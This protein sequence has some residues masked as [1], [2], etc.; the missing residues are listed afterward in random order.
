MTLDSYYQDH[1]IEVEPDRLEAYEQMFQWRDGLEPLIAPAKIVEGLSVVDYGCGPGHLAMEIAR[2]VGK[3]GQV[4]GLDINEEFISRTRARALDQG[5]EARVNTEL[6]EGEELPL[7]DASVD[8]V[9][10]K[11]VLEYVPDPDAT[12]REFRRV[13]HPGGLAHVTDSDWGSLIVEPLE[14]G[15]VSAL[16]AAAAVAFRTPLIGR[17]L[18]GI[19]R[20]AGFE[21]VRVRVMANADTQGSLRPVIANMTSYARASGQLDEP[22]LQAFLADVDAAI[23]E[24]S[25]LGVLPQFLVT[26]SA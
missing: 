15:R 25:F 7:A 20:R 14:R 5:L 19:F 16:M 1:W 8:R 21:D 6:M 17:R 23:E 10:C 9:L 12:V 11:N 18:Y 4:W 26:G 24:G 22:D 3:S 2:R 13:L